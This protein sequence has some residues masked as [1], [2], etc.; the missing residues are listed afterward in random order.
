MNYKGYQKNY[1]SIPQY[2]M[3][4]FHMQRFNFIDFMVIELRFFKKKNKN[5]NKKMETWQK[6]EKHFLIYYTHFTS[7]HI[8]FLYTRYFSCIF[9]LDIIKS[10]IN[11][12][13]KVKMKN[14]L[15]YGFQWGY[16]IAIP[17]YTVLPYCVIQAKIRQFEKRFNALKKSSREC[18]ERLK[19]PCQEGS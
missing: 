9:Y 16:T 1:T 2:V 15:I 11:L 6:C 7:Q 14:T 12:K 13:L 17:I 5:N 3:I 18:L 10:E 19:S 8:Q 4:H